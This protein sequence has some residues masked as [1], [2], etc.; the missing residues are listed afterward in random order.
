MGEKADTA[1]V[2]KISSVVDAIISDC[3]FFMVVVVRRDGT[4]ASMALLMIV[5]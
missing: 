2:K 3:S 5:W 1:V 4:V